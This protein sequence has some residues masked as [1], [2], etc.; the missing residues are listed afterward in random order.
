VIDGVLATP[1]RKGER[2]DLKLDSG[3]FGLPADAH[4]RNR[5]ARNSGG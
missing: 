3:F 2:V 5:Q 1:F 4:E